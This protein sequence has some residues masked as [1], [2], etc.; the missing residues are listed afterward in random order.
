MLAVASAALDPDRVDSVVQVESPAGDFALLREKPIEGI[1]AGLRG[2]EAARA[3]EVD[4]LVQLVRRR[5]IDCSSRSSC[6]RSRLSSRSE[7]A[8]Y[9]STPAGLLM[10]VYRRAQGCG[11]SPLRGSTVS[12]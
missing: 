9:S 12:R 2:G 11:P 6:V 7:R 1:L 4:P 3:D 8:A 10:P 5:E